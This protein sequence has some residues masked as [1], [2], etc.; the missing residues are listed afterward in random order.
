MITCSGSSFNTNSG[1]KEREV[2]GKSVACAE[3]D[4]KAGIASIWRK[5]TEIL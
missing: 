5:D 4:E 2:V 3:K 1:R